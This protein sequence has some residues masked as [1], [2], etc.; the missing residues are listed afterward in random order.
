MF[1]EEP[2]WALE[3]QNYQLTEAQK[4]M[5]TNFIVL[6]ADVFLN[7]GMRT[8]TSTDHFCKSV[9]FYRNKKKAYCTEGNV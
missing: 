8:Q 5:P 3:S 4:V 2:L 7:V 6:N 9:Q 1:Y